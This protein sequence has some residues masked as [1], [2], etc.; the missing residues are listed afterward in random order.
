MELSNEL[1]DGRGNGERSL[2]DKLPVIVIVGLG[3]WSDLAPRAGISP[4]DQLWSAGK[5][6]IDRSG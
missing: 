4:R 1:R 2:I 5:G 3:C 6:I